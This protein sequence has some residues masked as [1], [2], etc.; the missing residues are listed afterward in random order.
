MINYTLIRSKRKILAIQITKEAVIKVRAPLKLPLRE[1]EK[2]L[3]QK[4][5]WIEKTRQ[6]VLSQNE[7]MT[8]PSFSK[9]QEQ[10]LIQKAKELLPAKVEHYA[11]LLNVTPTAVKVGCAKTR[12]GS[13]SAKNSLNFSWRLM[14]VDEDAIDYVVVH[15]LAHIKEHNHG[16]RFWAIVES[17]LPDYKVRRKKLKDAI[18]YLK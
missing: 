15:E 2:F 13:C 14:L 1:I 12:W 3:L 11:G 17:I 7:K 16:K 4:Q 8:V 6:K 5:C 18:P 9:E 10:K